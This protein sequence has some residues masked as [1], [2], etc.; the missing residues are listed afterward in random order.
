MI[1]FFSNDLKEIN[2]KINNL[3]KKIDKL[4][5][6]FQKEFTN[7]QQSIDYIN[8]KEAFL[9]KENYSNINKIHAVHVAYNNASE[10]FNFIKKL[11]DNEDVFYMADTHST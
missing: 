8:F 2:K 6:K 5:K 9:I 3:K 7:S 4:N 11:T 1:Y 10:K